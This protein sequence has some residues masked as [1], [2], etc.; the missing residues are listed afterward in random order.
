MAGS[1]SSLSN[2]RTLKYHA[3]YP[4][5]F[6]TLAEAR[7]WMGDFID[8]Y[9]TV[10]RHSGLGYITP[11]Q[12]RKGEELQLF[13]LRT[14]TLQKVFAEHLERF[15]RKRPKEWKRKRVVYLNPS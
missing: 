4:G 7:N 14:Q 12:R 3:A 6:R 1:F 5:R 13:A 15:S 11:E 10:H 2:F 8:C 9:N